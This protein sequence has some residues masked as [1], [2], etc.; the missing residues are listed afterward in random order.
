[1][2]TTR[3][4]KF[5]AAVRADFDLG[6]PVYEI[7]LDEA[8]SVIDELDG[9]P[10][11]AIVERRQQRMLLSRLLSQLALPG[12]V[13]GKSTPAPASVHGRRAAEARWR[14]AATS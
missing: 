9:L 6:D 14:R 4:A 11:G 8:A 1:M 5:A 12:D 2:P 7:L 13:D 3:G 10:A